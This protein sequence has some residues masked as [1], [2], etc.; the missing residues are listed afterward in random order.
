MA[1]L[2]ASHWSGSMSAKSLRSLTGFPSLRTKPCERVAVHSRAGGF[3]LEPPAAFSLQARLI[4]IR[5]DADTLT[6]KVEQLSIRDGGC[7]QH[8][9]DAEFPDHIDTFS[10]REGFRRGGF[11]PC[12]MESRE[13][14]RPAFDQGDI[15]KV[16]GFEK[17]DG[18]CADAAGQ[19]PCL[20]TAN[21]LPW[22]SVEAACLGI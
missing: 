7:A 8:R 5:E 21:L 18:Q 4:C 3:E 12:K 20:F 15:G 16:A 2:S 19:G 14:V 13:K 9:D 10:E 1:S 6:L 17:T 11:A 22:I